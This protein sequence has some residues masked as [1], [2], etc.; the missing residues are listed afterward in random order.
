MSKTLMTNLSVSAAALA[1]TCRD[2][3]STWIDREKGNP[4]LSKFSAAASAALEDYLKTNPEPAP[5]QDIPFPV[6]F[7][8][9]EVTEFRE[10]LDSIFMPP[11]GPRFD[12]LV[13][14]NG[15][16]E[17]RRRQ[18]ILYAFCYDLIKY[19]GL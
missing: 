13:E 17:T 10:T 1:D 18:G 6:D 4:L 5:G 15:I 14:K 19:F 11:Q 16:S 8:P 9:G 2:L 12:I 7:N 3:G